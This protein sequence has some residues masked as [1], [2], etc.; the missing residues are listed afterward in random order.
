[1]KTTQRATW[2]T[3]GLAAAASAALVLAS[4][5]DGNGGGDEDADEIVFGFALSQSGDMAPFDVE[6]GEAA[7]LR[8]EELNEE[9]GIGGREIRTISRDV[10]SNPETVGSA[11]TELLAEDIDVL[12]L[13]CDF[14][15]AAPGAAAAQSAEVPGISL[16]AGAPQ[17][18][19]RST[20]GDYIFTAGIGSDSQAVTTAA[21]AYDQGWENGFLLQDESIE[22]TQQ[23]GAYFAP[24]FEDLGGEIIGTDA[25]PGG[26]NVNI[27]S[28]AQS[29]NN[30]DPQPDFV[31]VAS[32]NPGGATASRQLR[33][34][35]VEVPIVGSVAMDGEAL[36]DIMGSGA[37]D[38]YYPAAACYVYCEGFESEELDAFVDAFTEA[39]GSAP[40]SGY[41]LFGYNMMSGIAE[42]LEDVDSLEGEAIRDA[43]VVGDP[44]ETPIGEVDFFSE[45]CHKIIDMPL[46]F[47]EVVDGE[48]RYVDQQQPVAI[49]DIGDGN[50]CA[51]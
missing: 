34:A 33:E 27:A 3:M 1:M 29:I 16:C 47:S 41:A 12:I 15:L 37:S 40:S 45:T 11:A 19:D 43:L 31:Y 32:W 30:M 22:Y 24:A 28:Q 25:F 49:P 7:M 8:I 26:D 2:R 50:T 4:C 46:T 42:A 10:Q 21:W 44:V 5:G 20:L 6:P 36:L 51:E 13:P 14:D 35:G 23:L 39:T 9:G 48:A 18:A 17:I 38:V